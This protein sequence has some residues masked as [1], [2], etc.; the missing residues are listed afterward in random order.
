MPRQITSYLKGNLE[1]TQFFNSNVKGTPT[2]I[3]KASYFLL[4]IKIMR[5]SFD[6]FNTSQKTLLKE[7]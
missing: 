4:R 1:C 5:K 7:F 6:S 3:L 2:H